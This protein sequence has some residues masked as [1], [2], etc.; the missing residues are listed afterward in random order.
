MKMKQ[1]NNINSNLSNMLAKTIDYAG[2]YSQDSFRSILKEL[3]NKF[4][5]I[6][7]LDRNNELLTIKCFHS[8]QE[9]AIAKVTNGDN[10]TLPIITI[11]ENGTTD[12]TKRR[13]YSAVLVHE[14]FWDKDAQRAVRLLSFAPRAIN[15]NYKINIWAKYKQDLD[16]IRENI[17]LM[18]NPDLE[19]NSNYHSLNKAFITEEADTGQAI[20]DD[21]KDRVLQKSIGITVE[22]YIPNPK[23]LYTETGKIELFKQEIKLT[24]DTDYAK[25]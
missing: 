3:I 6:K 18:F 10:I 12:D 17:F 20:A 14:T 11:S 15:I 4:S 25:I 5:N 23:F 19:I 8:N 21:G 16:L 24:S 2:T 9:R 1:S 22:T 13:R 7:Y